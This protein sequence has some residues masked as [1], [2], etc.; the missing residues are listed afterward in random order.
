M[1]S[2]DKKM[3]CGFFKEG[4]YE[5]KVFSND[6]IFDEDGFIGRN[7]SASYSPDHGTEN[8]EPYTLD[9]KKLFKKYSNSSYLHM[10]NLTRTYIGEV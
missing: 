9:L 8:Y 6:L 7:I 2:E 1:N 3:F 4:I 5:Y 10:P